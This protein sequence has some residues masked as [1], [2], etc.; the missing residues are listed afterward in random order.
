MNPPIPSGEPL[1][2]PPA[3]GGSPPFWF[4]SFCLSSYFGCWG[5]C[6]PCTGTCEGGTWPFA[7]QKS[8]SSAFT[9]PASPVS[10]CA[11]P[12]SLGGQG[13]QERLSRRTERGPRNCGVGWM[14]PR[15][16]SQ[17]MGVLEAGILLALEGPTHRQRDRVDHSDP[18]G[19]TSEPTCDWLSAVRLGRGVLLSWPLCKVPMPTF[20]K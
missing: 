19:C 20:L 3:R 2:P 4:V 13:Y 11:K 1:P 12:S 17:G 7:R 14:W 5:G 8:M 15:R 6:Q 9:C 10:L 16:G 18:I